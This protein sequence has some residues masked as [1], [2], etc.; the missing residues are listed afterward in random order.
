M[1]ESSVSPLLIVARL[2][3]SC[4]VASWARTA[5]AIAVM[6]G[7]AGCG[8]SGG[9]GTKGETIYRAGPIAFRLPE[10]PPTWRQIKV[11][12]ASLSYRDDV[13]DASILVNGRCTTLD[14]DTPLLA[15]TNHLV[16]G[17]TERTVESQSVEPFDGREALHTRL[18][19]KLDG[20]PFGFDIFVLKK[21]G[22][23]YDFVYVASRDVIDGGAPVFDAFVRGF[24]TLPGSGAKI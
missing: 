16:M 15:L 14:G 19:A 9:Q 23:V 1:R 22:C 5:L 10:T 24:R 7:V 8:A 12:H 17:T 6:C 21:D 4:A 2:V 20:V 13:H 18:T 11:S 3:L